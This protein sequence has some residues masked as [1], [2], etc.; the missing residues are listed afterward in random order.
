[1][2]GKIPSIYPL[3]RAIISPSEMLVAPFPGGKPMGV[4]VHYL[5]DRDVERARRA[6][7]EKKLGYHLVIDRDGSVTQLA[8]LSHSVSHAG[9]ASWRELSPN[10]WHAAVA[11]AGWGK[12]DDKGRAWNG[13]VIPTAERRKGPDVLG[14]A[15]LWDAATEPQASALISVLTWFVAMGIDPR[16][17]CGHDEA[18]LPIG[19]K[20]D[21]GGSLPWTMDELR[22]AIVLADDDGVS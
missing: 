5:A 17:V 6:L 12:L 22:R 21:P 4:T 20:V 2:V 13:A 10:R 15:C 9:K 11:L 16:N 18:A 14:K 8:Y 3:V 1:M 7:R 19:R